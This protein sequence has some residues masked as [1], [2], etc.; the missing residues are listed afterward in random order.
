MSCLLEVKDLSVSVENGRLVE[1]V[2]FEVNSG[3]ALVILGE[4][5]SGKSLLANAIIGNL[6]DTLTS[7]GQVRLFDRCQSERTQEERESLWGRD[8]SVLPQEPWFALSPLMAAGEQVKEVDQLVNG[9]S[10]NTLLNRLKEAFQKVN[11]SGDES[12][13]PSQLSGGMAQRVAYISATQGGGKLLIADEPT[14]GLDAS[15]QKQIGEQLNAHKSKGAVLVI[16]HDVELA[17]SLGGEVIVMRKGVVV[18]RGKSEEVLKAPKSDY[19]KA[20]ISAHPK[21]WQQRQVSSKLETMIKASE[22]KMVRNGKTLFEDLEFA[23]SKNSVIGIS[24]DSGKGK[25]TLADIVLGLV[26]PTAGSL[27]FQEKLA[28]GKALKLYQDPPSALSRAVP[29]QTLLDDIRK[30]C[31]FDDGQVR[32][33]LKRLNLDESLLGRKSTQVSG[34]ELQRFAI[35][36][37]LLMGPSLLIA[38]EPTS[39]LDPITAANTLKLLVELSEEQ[40][41]TLLLISHDKV[42]LSKLCDQVIQI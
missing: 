18:E 10:G 28:K 25:S 33:Y 14:K 21:N 6:P 7:S 36:R 13:L 16:T 23:I 11:L 40:G 22:L 35:L 24:G 41:F 42:A 30:V 31:Q 34:G 2:S 8:I 9:I 37:A 26:T 20:L 4:T 27:K 38:D 32:R 29:L 12:K 3:E 5:G 19:A 39:R 1:P 17:E 15:R